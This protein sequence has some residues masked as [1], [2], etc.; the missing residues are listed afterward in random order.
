MDLTPLFQQCVDI[1]ASEIKPQATPEKPEQ[2]HP[3]VSDNFNQLCG[4]VYLVAKELDSFLNEIKPTYL[5]IDNFSLEEK[6]RID[7]EF[8]VNLQQLYQKLKALQQRETQRVEATSKANS[9][10]SIWANLLGENDEKDSWMASVAAH[11][12]Q[13]LKYLNLK[14]N[15][16]GK[17]FDAMARKRLVRERQL[18]SLN[19]Q[20]INEDDDND[21]DLN[22]LEDVPE[23]I[24]NQDYN[25]V[26]LQ[27]EAEQA[28]RNR[29][30]HYELSQE[31]L[32]QLEEDNRELLAAK[33]KQLK[34]VEQLH[35]SM[36]DIV[37]LQAELTFQLETQASQIDNLI[38]AQ[39]QMELDVISGNKEMKSATR[40]NKRAANILVMAIYILGVLILVVDFLK[41]Y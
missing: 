11:R 4:D 38:D 36:V 8:G 15:G 5:D 29:G 21:Y 16:V 14:L 1:V 32:Q 7:E 23:D 2:K 35:T 28:L 10:R 34:S 40:R 19:F 26:A 27:E 20:N 22:D 31:Q 41:F 6:N 13:V 17:R 25:Q 18:D 3:V 39:S 37:N 12:N 33:S 9:K 24:D 30:G